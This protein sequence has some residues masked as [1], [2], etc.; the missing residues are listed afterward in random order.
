MFRKIHSNR[1]PQAT[2]IAE[3]KNEFK[4][5]F[6][7]SSVAITQKM[8]KRPKFVFI[9]MV[10]SMLLSAGLSFTVFRNK[11]TADKGNEMLHPKPKVN[12]IS[13][14]FDQISKTARLIKQT[15]HLKQEIDSI[16]AKRTL[17]KQDSDMLENDLDQLRWL[18]QPSKP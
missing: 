8:Q 5:Y 9:I 1:D 16:S 7:K 11:K 17:T 4:I 3:L 14:G 18:N 15:L 10:S 13:D 2:V 6:E 12:A